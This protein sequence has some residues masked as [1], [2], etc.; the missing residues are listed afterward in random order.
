MLKITLEA[1]RVNAG[2]TQKGAAEKLGI[3]NTTLCN[4]EKGTSF[5]NAQQIDQIC[6][7]YGLSYDNI[8]FLPNNPL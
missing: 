8:I 5:P 3:S 2:Y 4:W 1:A 6:S 7:L